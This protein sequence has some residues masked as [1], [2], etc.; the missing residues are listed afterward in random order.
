[1]TSSPEVILFVWLM[2]SHFSNKQ[3]RWELEL[4]VSYSSIFILTTFPLTCVI[5]DKK[6]S[7]KL[8]VNSKLNLGTSSLCEHYSLYIGLN[9]LVQ[10]FSF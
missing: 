10:W 9:D 6:I 8:T 5:C 4:M 1:M 7:A 2:P 3:G